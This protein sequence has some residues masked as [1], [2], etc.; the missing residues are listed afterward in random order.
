MKDIAALVLVCAIVLCIVALTAT[1]II[2]RVR[3]W[4]DEDENRK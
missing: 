2:D 1:F 3:E 4:R